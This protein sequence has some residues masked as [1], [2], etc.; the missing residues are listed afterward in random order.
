[1]YVPLS[2]A[3]CLATLLL[4]II[5]VFTVCSDHLK[6]NSFSFSSDHSKCVC[7]GTGQKCT[8]SA[9]GDNAAA[10]PGVSMYAGGASTVSAS[11][12]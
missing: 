7:G 1:M 9:Q 3:H 6:H 2:L 12:M 5:T 11:Y 10:Q 4:V 8:S